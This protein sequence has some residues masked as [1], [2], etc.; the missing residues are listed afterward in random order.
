MTLREGDKANNSYATKTLSTD[1]SDK[2]MPSLLIHAEHTPKIVDDNATVRKNN[3]EQRVSPRIDIQN[4]QPS[5]ALVIGALNDDGHTIDEA[6]D[7]EPHGKER[8][9]LDEDDLLGE[10][11]QDAIQPMD[12]EDKRAMIEKPDVIRST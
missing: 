11:E 5:D 8:M 10:E 6:M 2:R 4:V 3:S 12:V 9:I 7:E 1:S